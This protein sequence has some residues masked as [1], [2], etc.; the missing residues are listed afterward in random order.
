MT[1]PRD[2]DE[3]EQTLL[4]GASVEDRPPPAKPGHGET[5][6]HPAA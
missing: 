2:P 5:P 3:V 4:P 1:S 6:R